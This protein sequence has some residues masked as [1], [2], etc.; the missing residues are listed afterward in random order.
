MLGGPYCNLGNSSSVDNN[1]RRVIMMVIVSRGPLS[2][3]LDTVLRSGWCCW[4]LALPTPGQVFLT[5]LDLS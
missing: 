5:T 2:V 4:C 3:E 1:G